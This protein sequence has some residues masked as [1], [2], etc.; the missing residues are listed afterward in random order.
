VALVPDTGKRAC[1]NLAFMVQGL[2]RNGKPL[3]DLLSDNQGSRTST[4]GQFFHVLP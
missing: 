4:S 1:D 2:L 3:S